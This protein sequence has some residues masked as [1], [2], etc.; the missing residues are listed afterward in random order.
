MK[1]QR[2]GYRAALGSGIRQ[3]PGEVGIYVDHEKCTGLGNIGIM[4]WEISWGYIISYFK[5]Y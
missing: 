2:K 4:I 1:V 3:L 5:E